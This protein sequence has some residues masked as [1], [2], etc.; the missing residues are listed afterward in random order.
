[1]AKINTRGEIVFTKL[2]PHLVIA[3][4]FD[5]YIKY[6]YEPTWVSTTTY[7]YSKGDTA[8]HEHALFFRLSLFHNA[9][10]VR[11]FELFSYAHYDYGV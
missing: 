4:K 2:T 11:H 1:M 10:V 5:L 6:R 7:D 8:G 9:K 3:K